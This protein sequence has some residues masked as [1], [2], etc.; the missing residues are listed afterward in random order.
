MAFDIVFKRTGLGNGK[1]PHQENKFWSWHA[2][3][4][5]SQG[6]MGPW[7]Y[8][9]PL[10]NIAPEGH[11]RR[12]RAHLLCWCQVW[13]QADVGVI[14]WSVCCAVVPTVVCYTCHSP[15]R[16]KV[17]LESLRHGSVDSFY[18]LNELQKSR[19]GKGCMTFLIAV[20]SHCD[21]VQ[22]FSAWTPVPHVFMSKRVMET[23]IFKLVQY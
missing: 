13:E 7:E 20:S 18:I 8:W 22:Y 4:R 6:K 2:W 23:T 10:D 9:W 14:G 21:R 15:Q 3:E 5:E 12:L 16:A 19:G 17:L 1:L 11:S